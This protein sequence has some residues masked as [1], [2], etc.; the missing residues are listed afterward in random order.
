MLPS[1]KRASDLPPFSLPLSLSPPREIAE[2]YSGGGS[3]RE[4]RLYEIAP[5]ASGMIPFP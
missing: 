2:D 5:L 1:T 3:T 4:A